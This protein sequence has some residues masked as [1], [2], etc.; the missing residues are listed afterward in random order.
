M[1]VIELSGVPSGLGQARILAFTV[2]NFRMKNVGRA[3]PPIA[4]GRD[5]VNG[6]VGM[7]DAQLRSESGRRV[8][9]IIRLL[10]PFKRRGIPTGREEGSD[11]ILSLCQH[12][13]GILAPI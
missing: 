11:S 8:A 12:C 3:C 10:K 2:V 4:A 6:S 1:G 5:P 7:L 13:G 9:I